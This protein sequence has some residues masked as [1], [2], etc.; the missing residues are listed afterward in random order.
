MYVLAT[1]RDTITEPPALFGEDQHQVLAL[2]VEKKYAN[3]VRALRALLSCR[4]P[5]VRSRALAIAGGPG[6]GAVRVLLRP[7]GC[8]RFSRLPRRRIRTH[9]Q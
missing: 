4:A 6:C 7:R 5:S 9:G 2:Q 3:R 1:M 8:W